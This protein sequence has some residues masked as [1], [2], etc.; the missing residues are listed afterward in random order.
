MSD[1]FSV[2]TCTLFSQM[3]RS[4]LK[5]VC[6][7]VS[8]QKYSERYRENRFVCLSTSSNRGELA[9]YPDRIQ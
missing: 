7:E 8:V 4:L 2:D 5:F 1:Y 3:K 9:L 6:L